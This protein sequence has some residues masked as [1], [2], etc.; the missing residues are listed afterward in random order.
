MMS[1]YKNSENESESMESW[2]N[3]DKKSFE[4][5]ELINN[6]NDYG[7]ISLQEGELKRAEFIPLE[8]YQNSQNKRKAGKDAM[9]ETQ[10]NVSLI[11]Q[12]AYE[13]GFVQGEK[14][15]FELGEKKANKVIEN[16]ERLFDEISS[17]KQE[18]LKQH[19]KEILDLTFAIAEK[20]VHHL[21]KFDESGVKEAVFNALNLAIEKSK[22]ILNVNPE[23]YDY[24]EKLRPELFKEYKELKSITVTSDPS[25]TRGGCYLKTPYSDIDAGIETQLEKIYQCLQDAFCEKENV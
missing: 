15:G 11:E 5:N 22:I 21:T 14:D 17:F 6:K 4:K 18:I 8:E 23:D 10:R 3:Y 12:E 2:T 16:I 7:F 1:L 25:V 9:I 24:I 13:E 19:E 20:I